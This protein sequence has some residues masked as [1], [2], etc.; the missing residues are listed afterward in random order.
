MNNNVLEYVR[1]ILPDS[2]E[3]QKFYIL[4]YIHARRMKEN[5]KRGEKNVIIVNL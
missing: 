1:V 5:I 2:G 4:F 3:R